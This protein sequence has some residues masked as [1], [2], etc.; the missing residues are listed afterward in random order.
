MTHR[1]KLP[2]LLAMLVSGAAQGTVGGFDGLSREAGFTNH[3]RHGSSFTT[4]LSA[5]M[6]L[7]ATAATPG[8]GPLAGA[9]PTSFGRS[10]GTAGFDLTSFDL[11]A[12]DS[13]PAPF[14]VTGFRGIVP[15]SS[16]LSTDYGDFVGVPGADG[17]FNH[18]LF[19]RNF[20]GV[21]SNFG[22]AP[23]GESD[24]VQPLAEP[25]AWAM[26]FAGFGA[27]GYALRG[28]RRRV[29]ISFA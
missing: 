15:G 14:N 9:R 4:R 26:L 1:T 12:L 29:H 8:V 10:A 11:V 20:V 17:A 19:S 21:S 22:N 27:V 13:P 24:I 25:A 18:V 6:D 23:A 16:A 28:R 2:L 5:I 3:T 7:A